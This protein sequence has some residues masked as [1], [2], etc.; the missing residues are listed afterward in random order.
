[1][2]H[3]VIAP[4]LLPAFAA[5]ACVLTGRRLGLQR[6][7]GLGSSVVL[8]LTSIALL[9]QAAQGATQVYELGNWPAPFGIVLVL[10]RL[11]ALMLLLTSLVVLAASAS[12]IRGADAHGSH[13]HALLLFQTMGLNGAFLTGDLFNLFVFFEVL[14]IASYGLLTHGGGEQ[15]LRAG[16]HYVVINLTGSALFLIA[17]SLLYGVTGTL[18]LADLS[19]RAATLPQSDAAL[20]RAAGLLLFGVFAIKAAAFPLYFWLPAAYTAASAPVAA[21]FAIMTKVGVYSIMRVS[22]I[23]FG[24]G[25]GVA[26][27]LIDGWLLPV[28]LLTLA[29][30]TIGALAA[31]S[32]RRLVAYLTVA[33]VG[34]LLT[35]VGLSGEPALAAGLYYM[36]HSTLTI[37]ALFLV[38][39][40]IAGNRGEGADRLKS[41]APQ[42]A[43]A[44]GLFLVSAVAVAGLPPLPGFI[45]K[46][47]LL[48]AAVGRPEMAWVWGVVLVAG[49]MSV[50]ALARAGS[51]LFWKTLKGAPAAVALPMAQAAPAIALIA[52]LLLLSVFAGP[53]KRY[54]DATAAQLADVAGYRAAVRGTGAEAEGIPR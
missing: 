33:S 7:V 42:P 39:D 2:S 26:A 24:P 45:G 10:D 19:Q 1:M 29:L 21:A 48:D 54:A 37:A 41:A 23:G 28:A 35:A 30:G 31:M 34:T 6:A 17:V 25:A 46:A 5:M 51:L 3:W 36:V 50:I 12:A 11:S 22:G 14:L 18:N 53:V 32:L 38:A 43:L 4:I 15:R 44:G 52:A 9:F 8:V 20:L 40:L 16:V 27:N 47:L 49:L 13:F